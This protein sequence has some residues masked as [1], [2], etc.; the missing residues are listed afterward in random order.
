MMN[1]SVLG[2]VLAGGLATRLG[3]VDKVLLSLGA[4]QILD[5]ILERFVSQVDCLVINANGDPSRF[6]N[7]DYPVI[8]DTLDG[9]LGPLA[10]VLAAMHCAKEKDK[11]F[12][13]SVAG[14]T[15]FFPRN[16]VNK[17]LLTIQQDGTSIGLA[18]S[19]NEQRQIW[20]RQPTFGL[21]DVSLASVLECALINGVRKIVGWTDTIGCSSVRFSRD[22]NGYDPFF[23]V[24]TLHDLM[25]VQQAFEDK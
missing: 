9:Y 12:V 23:N 15:P 7:Y 17:C 3:G 16:F 2:V 19:Y 14:D 11:K 25:V 1:K 5:V 10:G 24:N 8:A 20:M 22:E 13:A 4:Q 21:W 6:N 18:A